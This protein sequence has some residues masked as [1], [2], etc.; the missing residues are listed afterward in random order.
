MPAIRA[1]DARQ[2]DLI[3]NPGDDRIGGG[4]DRPPAGQRFADFIL[5]SE[6]Q[7]ILTSHGFL[8]GC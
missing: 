3:E 1:L 8:P 5:S 6:A 4:R 7:K 2:G